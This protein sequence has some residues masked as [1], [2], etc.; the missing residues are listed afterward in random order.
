M[1]K[2]EDSTASADA[3]AAG[4][5][6]AQSAQ[7]AADSKWVDRLARVGLASRGLV[8]VLIAVLAVQIAF[9]DSGEK[10]DQQGA[11]STL[12]QNGFGK[13]LLW[14]V[15]VGFLGY[16]VWQVTEAGW[17]HRDADGEGKR[18]LQRIG[19]LVQA[20][21]YAGLAFVAAR[22]AA[23]SGGGGNGGED[24]TSKLLG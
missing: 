11:F 2:V 6:A 9:G 1:T 19:S 15:V 17:G 14:L 4:R 24:A 20:V 12:A 13:A 5:Q 22:T 7:Q 3:R 10:A 16:A 21:M 23:G 8:Y 18:T